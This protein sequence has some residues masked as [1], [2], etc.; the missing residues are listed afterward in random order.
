MKNIYFSL[1]LLFFCFVATA[2]II[3]IPD[4][5]FKAV[6]LFSNTNN[7]VAKN[8]TGTNIKIDTNSDGEIQLSEALNVFQLNVT[9][10]SMADITSMVG[11][12]HFTNLTYLNCSNNAI[13]SLDVTALSHLEFLQS[14]SGILN[15][16]N[17][18]GLSNLQKIYC[19]NNAI[20]SLDLTGLTN[21]IWLWCD[22]NNIATFDFNGLSSLKYVLCNNNQLTSINNT[23]NL[24]LIE[25]HCTNNNLTNLDLTGMTSLSY[26][27]CA[28]NNI[29]SINLQS[30][31]S[32]LTI[33]NCSGN[34]LTNLDIN[35]SSVGIL[36]VADTLL[37]S[38]DC[39]QSGV[40]QLSAYNCPNLQTINVR[41]G[42]MSMSDP[43][44]LFY[45]FRIEN[46]PNLVSI[47]TDNG[48]QNQLAL[49]NYNTSGNVVVYN[50][51]NCD[52]PVIVNMGIDDL[53]KL[54]LKL[55]PNPTSDIINIAVSNN[56]SINKAAVNNVL[57]QTILTFENTSA[58]DISALS[59]GTYFVTV[60]TDS[61]K[62]TQRIIKL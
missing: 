24:G 41:N 13:T 3:N 61:G 10:N 43:D 36:G 55:Y 42:V 38:I 11:I 16:L 12:E 15:S 59:K 56:Q 28:G 8:S 62:E 49:T 37:T 30:A 19:Y 53:N 47:C 4:A 44:L 20:T 18:T 58:L 48:E 31:M 39:S 46:N 33:V 60:E 27:D 50:G 25:F 35:G 9:T 51:P 22:N 45:A 17:V 14:N 54:T 2:Q 5:N 52:I 7:A 23:A 29:S 32:S 6:L 57:G 40:T 34:P 1:A 21:L 26:F